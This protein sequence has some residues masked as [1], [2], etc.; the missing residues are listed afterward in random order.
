MPPSAPA[1]PLLLRPYIQ[2][3]VLAGTLAWPSPPQ[4]LPRLRASLEEARGVGSALGEEARLAALLPSQHGLCTLAAPSPPG[5]TS[6]LSPR[7]GG[8]LRGPLL[9]LGG[10]TGLQLSPPG[11]HC[12]DTPR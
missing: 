2:G 3:V 9:G 6:R 11:M 5:P 10:P 4:P 7:P 8:S 1:A 12:S